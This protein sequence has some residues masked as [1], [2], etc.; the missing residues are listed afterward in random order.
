MLHHH[1]RSYIE[2]LEKDRRA[3]GVRRRLL[4]GVGEI[5]AVVVAAAA[6]DEAAWHTLLER[7]AARLRAVVRRHR[8][9]AHD[10]EDVVQT[11]WLRLFEHIDRMR[12]PL[13]VGAWLETTARRESL[14]ILRASQRE[15]LTES[16]R[17][18]LEP[19][20]AVAE[21]RLVASDDRAALTRGVTALAPRERQ[22]LSMLFAD[23]A[24]SYA[25]I[26]HTLGMPI[27]S[28]GPTRARILARLRR[29]PALAT[30]I[31]NAPG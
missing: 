22:L 30:A 23:P 31:G 25:E 7:F 19:V 11:T 18:G 1:N 10:A 24:P 15:R 5:D 14:R 29:D 16:E 2:S 12:E 28:I 8:L 3:I 20:A 4:E 21:Q 13:A 9:A 17:L 26:S 27:G 6:G